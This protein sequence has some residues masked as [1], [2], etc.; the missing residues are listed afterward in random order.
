M[1]SERK[2]RS[3]SRTIYYKEYQSLEQRLK[4]PEARRVYVIRKTVSEG[5]FAEGKMYHGLRKFMTRGI[6]KAQKKSYMI[7][8]VQNLKRLFGYLKRRTQKS[9]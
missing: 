6:E 8:T 5:L 9:V 7:A 2:R 3:V 4:T 1:L